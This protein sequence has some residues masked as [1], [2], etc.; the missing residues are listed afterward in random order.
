VQ[1]SLND[2]VGARE[3]HLWH[4]KA[5]GGRSYLID[6]QLVFGCRLHRQ[7]GGFLSFEDT[8]NGARRLRAA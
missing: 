8:I 5:D 7:V 6:Y 4:I 3:Q 2:F 1:G